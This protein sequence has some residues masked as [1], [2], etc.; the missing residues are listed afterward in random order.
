M[1]FDCTYF[2]SEN[3]SSLVITAL[4]E[5]RIIITRN[6]HLTKSVSLHIVELDAELIKDQLKEMM[7]KLSLKPDKDMLFSRCIIC[8]EPLIS[9]EKET[10]KDKIPEYVFKTTQDFVSCPVCKRI[11]WQGTHWG[12]VSEV[13]KEVGLL[14][15]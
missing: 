6:H 14:S 3:K 1:G 8:N 9:V 10:V 13:L 4:R 7:E 2:T 15:S 11:Y 12:N 5:G